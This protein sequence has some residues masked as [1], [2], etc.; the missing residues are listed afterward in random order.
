MGAAYRYIFKVL[1]EVEA[2]KI[3]QQKLFFAYF[4]IFGQKEVTL[5]LI[6]HCMIALRQALIGELLR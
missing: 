5:L 3:L 2:W 4:F 6:A 1:L